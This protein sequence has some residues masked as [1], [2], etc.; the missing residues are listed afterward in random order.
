MG[1]FPSRKRWASEIADYDYEKP[2]ASRR[3]SVAFP[4]VELLTAP[5]GDARVHTTLAMLDYMVLPTVERQFQPERLARAQGHLTRALQLDPDQLLANLLR[6]TQP[7]P[8]L[9]DWATAYHAWNYPR[10]AAVKSAYD[11][12]RFFDFPQSV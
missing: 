8:D 9:N 4:D 6:L 7:D 10:L 3:A 12:D 1:C 5:M 11:L 2:Q